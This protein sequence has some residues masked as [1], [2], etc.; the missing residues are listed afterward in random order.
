MH[1]CRPVCCGPVYSC[2]LIAC[3][4][5]IWAQACPQLLAA[6]MLHAAPELVTR[7]GGVASFR[8]RGTPTTRPTSSRV[9]S[10]SCTWRLYIKEDKFA[11]ISDGEESF[12][13]EHCL[14]TGCYSSAKGYLVA[15]EPGSAALALGDFQAQGDLTCRFTIDAPPHRPISIRC[16]WLTAQRAEAHV[17]WDLSSWDLPAAPI[18]HLLWC[19]GEPAG[20]DG[21]S[22]PLSRWACLNPTL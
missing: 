21:R 12:W 6:Q 5:S 14:R 2:L 18:L 19:L 3:S 16:V 9:R 20:T 4:A 17:W 15:L 1:S 8:S 10:T 22:G 11:Y 13:V 7:E